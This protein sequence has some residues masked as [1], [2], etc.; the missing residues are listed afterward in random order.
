MTYFTVLLGSNSLSG[1]RFLNTA[2]SGLVEIV[3]IT[4]SWMFLDYVDRR[5]SYMSITFVG[6]IA[7]AIGPVLQSQGRV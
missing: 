1:N 3:S 4:V 2:L 6:L 7:V 5:A